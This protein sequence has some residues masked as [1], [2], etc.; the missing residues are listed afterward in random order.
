[1]T[2]GVLAKGAGLSKVI[3][4]LWLSVLL[5]GLAVVYVSHQNRVL[6]TEL[7]V[8]EQKKHRLEVAWGQYLLEESS[9]ASLQRVEIL[10]RQK[11]TMQ[12][13]PLEEIVMVKP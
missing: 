13:P 9:L 8:L 2:R 11:L 5:S 4:V 7:A 1:M 6:Y 3:T 10:A 12:V